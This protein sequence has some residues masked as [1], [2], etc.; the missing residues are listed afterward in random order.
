MG[1]L[2]LALFLALKSIIKG[3]RWALL[4]IIM[5]M[6]LSFAN[7]LL[8]PSILAGVTETI[9]RQQVDTLFANIIIDPPPGS[10]YLDDAGRVEK[11]IAQIPGI[12]GF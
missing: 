10:Y 11:K 9:D 8:T 7:L 6:S 1:N 12:S 2:K 3:N 5:V 4:M